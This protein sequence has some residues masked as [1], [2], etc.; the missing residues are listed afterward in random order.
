MWSHP[1]WH[2]FLLDGWIF[3]M[4]HWLLDHIFLVASFLFFS[5]PQLVM[6]PVCQ[7][8]KEVQLLPD[9]DSHN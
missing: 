8:N 7:V 6:E 2:G 5:F 1:S 9:P 3:R 4:F